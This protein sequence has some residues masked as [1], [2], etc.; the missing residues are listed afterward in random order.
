M[1]EIQQEVLSYWLKKCPD[2]NGQYPSRTDIQVTDLRHRMAYVA[3]LDVHTSP[4]DFSYRLIGTRLREFLFEDYTGK[5]LRSLE[6]KGPGSKI[7][8]IL[9]RV[10]ST[11]EPL[12]CNVPYVGPKADFRQA[13]SLYLPLAGNHKQVDKIM[14]VTHFERINH[15]ECPDEFS[16][17][18][19]RIM[20]VMLDRAL[21]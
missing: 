12:Y 18:D 1:G 21:P 4:L 7:W 16:P 11:G 14:I 19:T 5:N 15:N 20:P 10:Y 13:S 8:E 2:V 3:V 6:G 17:V 9:S